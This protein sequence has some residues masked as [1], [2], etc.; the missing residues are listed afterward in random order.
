MSQTAATASPPAPA[1]LDPCNSTCGVHRVPYPFGFSAG[2]PIRFNCTPNT[3]FLGDAAAALTVRS[4]NSDSI[5][6]SLKPD[7]RRPAHFFRKLFSPNFAPTSRNAL[8]LKNCSSVFSV[9]TIPT[10]LVKT[11]FQLHDCGGDDLSCYADRNG[12]ELIDFDTLNRSGCGSLFS[13][14]WT[15]ANKSAGSDVNETAL[16]V[17]DSVVA[18]E[19]EMVELRWWLQGQCDSGDRCSSGADCQKVVL[20]GIREGFRCHC[21]EGYDGDGYIDGLGCRKVSSTCNRSKYVS[22]KCSGLT[23]VSVLIAGLAAGASLALLSLASICLCF[24]RKRQLTKFRKIARH[25]LSETETICIPIYSYKEVQRA[26]N[27]FS[28]EHRLGTGAYGTVYQAKLHNHEWVAIKRIKHREN[29]EC[30]EQVINEIKLLSSVNHPNLVHL[31]GCSIENI[32]EQILVYEFMP[33][34]TLFQHLQRERGD[35][36][37]LAWP[38]R[39]SIAMETAQAIAYLHSAI[40]PPIYHRDIKSSNILLDQNFKAKVADFGLSRLGLPESSFISTAPQGT[41]GYLD[42]QYHQSFHLSDKSD[43]YSFGVVLAE[44]ISGLKVVDFSRPSNE[45]NLAAYVTDRISKGCLDEIIDPLLK[46]ELH[47]PWTSASIHKVAELTFRCLAYHG[48]MRPSMVEVVAELEQL[49]SS[50]QDFVH[51]TLN[52]S[53]SPQTEPGLVVKKARFGS[54]G[55][56]I[57]ENDPGFESSMDLED[58]SCLSTQELWS[59]QHSSPLSNS[60]L[61]NNGV[62]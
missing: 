46:Q 50:R 51:S 9:C 7:C 21:R 31:L 6:I 23:K 24:H 17:G 14:I 37:G 25:H 19:I 52:S 57:L 49:V 58:G 35:A 5:M 42:P 4:V 8:L 47:D 39:L 32:E 60:L 59:S 18:L 30:I 13:S 36:K 44:I 40:N 55:F 12:G 29:S 48:D 53:S 27:S 41:P 45:V 62:H 3:V 22:G 20:Q 56:L 33:N 15:E 16:E 61:A 38:I 43:V 26:T 11:T 34:G 10:T 2:C 54:L 28:E 1:F